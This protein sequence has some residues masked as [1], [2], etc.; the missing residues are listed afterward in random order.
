L[1]TKPSH[2]PACRH[3]FWND[4]TFESQMRARSAEIEELTGLL[5][6]TREEP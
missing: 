2:T 4:P 3:I 6:P 5:L 1:G